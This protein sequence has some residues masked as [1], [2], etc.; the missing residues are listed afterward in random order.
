MPFH[1]FI[2]IIEAGRNFIS[3]EKL[4]YLQDG[5]SETSVLPMVTLTQ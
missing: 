2:Q 5:F 1:V 3:G 4:S